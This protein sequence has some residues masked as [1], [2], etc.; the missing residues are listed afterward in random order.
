MNDHHRWLI[1]QSMEHAKF[2]DEQ[3]EEL[4][5]KIEEYLQPYRRQYEW[6]MTMPGIKEAS[7]AN[8]LAEIGPNMEQFPDGD[9]LSS[10]AGSWAGICPSNNRMAGK[11]KSSHINK[12]NKFL[13]ASLVEAAWGATRK[14][15]SASATQ[16][17]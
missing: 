1:E 17:L 15:G 6:L 2:V 11:S 7:G 16:V 9:H 12:A 8:V 14:R 10:W 13:V 3:V 4:E 5:K